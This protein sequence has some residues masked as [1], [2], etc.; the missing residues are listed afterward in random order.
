MIVSI[1]FP[2]PTPPP[3]TNT[4]SAIG[5]FWIGYLGNKTEHVGTPQI[6]LKLFLSL[7]HDVSID[8]FWKPIVEDGGDQIYDHDKIHFREVNLE[9]LSQ[10]RQPWHYHFRN[11]VFRYL[12]NLILL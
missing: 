3:F 7:K 11:A 12:E 6:K 10:Y 2:L 5:S 9:R 4:G 1:Q 8:L